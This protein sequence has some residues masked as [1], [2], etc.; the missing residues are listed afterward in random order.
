MHLYREHRLLSVGTGSVILRHRISNRCLYILIIS[1]E[2][3]LLI[4]TDSTRHTNVVISQG[5]RQVLDPDIILWGDSLLLGIQ[6]EDSHLVWE[7]AG[8]LF[9]A[10]A[11]GD[12]AG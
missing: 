2:I 7:M 10:L 5:I 11:S 12:S 9:R 1:E 4:A 8:C 3:F 6:A